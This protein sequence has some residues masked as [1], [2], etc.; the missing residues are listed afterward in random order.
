MRAMATIKNITN[1]IFKKFKIWLINSR[2]FFF[3]WY[4]KDFQETQESERSLKEL[5]SDVKQKLVDAIENL[6]NNVAEQ[7]VIIS[8]IDKAFHR[9]Q[10]NPSHIN[11]SVVILSSPVTVIS[12]ILSEALQ[13][14]M[15]Q[16]QASMKLLA[17][18][19]R[20]TTITTIKD[21]LEHYLA[22]QSQE[23]NS[24]I[25]QLEV[26]V[27]PN[28]DWCF[29]RSLEGLEGIEYLRSLL[30]KNFQNRFWILGANQVGWEYL[31]LVDRFEAYC[32]EVIILPENEPEE[33]QKWLK[34]IIDQF[35]ITFEPPNIDKQ[36]LDNNKDNQTHYFDRLASI[37]QGVSTVAIEGFLASICQCQT[38]E[39]DST[40]KQLIAQMPN[41]PELPALE[42]AD[43]YLLY[44][45]L[46]HGDLSIGALV[47]S[48]A[49][50]ESE[51][52]ARVQVLLRKGIVEQQE[53]VLTINP[54]HYPKLKQEL[55][56][57]NFIIDKQ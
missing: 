22:S 51:V 46:L 25:Q 23:N 28:L 12:R 32:G 19:A 18:N 27:I 35:H 48:L 41:L 5:S 4:Q 16:K 29:L 40:E 3:Y 36:L 31:N 9:W 21:K 26:T 15:Q 55:A 6:P 54:I 8:T 2:N 10:E 37:S 11:N 57:N 33:L 13:E 50:E 49:D 20:P 17:L 52:Q 34:P 47:E 38:E 7:Q 1:K 44:S 56:S 14:W 39:E 30:C 43:R 42:P 24:E 45:L 53:R